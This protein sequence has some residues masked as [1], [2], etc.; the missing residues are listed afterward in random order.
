MP[1]KADL[2]EDG[3]FDLSGR[4]DIVMALSVLPLL[5]KDI[6][7]KAVENENVKY[8]LLNALSGCYGRYALLLAAE[9]LYA[10]DM[11]QPSTVCALITEQ[12]CYWDQPDFI[13]I[14]LIGRY[15]ENDAKAI[16]EDALTD[17]VLK[18]NFLFNNGCWLFTGRD[19]VPNEREYIP[20]V[21]M[22]WNYH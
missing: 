18:R 11:P 16:A 14:L 3:Y 10:L 2:Q 9:A 15:A 20:Q 19:D 4:I 7:A 22:L 12:D 17:S 21:K 6:V 1:G 8:T 5:P 13:R